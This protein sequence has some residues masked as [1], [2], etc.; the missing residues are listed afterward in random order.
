MSFV[1]A[2]LAIVAV[3]SMWA[4]NTVVVSGRI[5]DTATGLPIEGAAIVLAPGSPD[6]TRQMHFTDSGGNYSFDEVASGKGQVEITAK[7]FLPFQ[8]TNP[9]DVSIEIATDHAE[10]NF[11]LTPTASITGRI[12]DPEADTLRPARASLFR[13]DYTDG[14][15]RFAAVAGSGGSARIESDGS[16]RFTGL[17]PGRYIVCAGAGAGNGMSFAGHRNPDGTFTS[18]RI[19]VYPDIYY[20]GTTVFADAL[21]VTLAAGQDRTAEFKVARGPLFRASGVVDLPGF[22]G[23]AGF[24]DI[25]AIGDGSTQHV[26][27]GSASI[28]PGPFVVEGM[29][30][31]QYVVRSVIVPPSMIQVNVPFT[32][33]DRDIEDLKIVPQQELQMQGS[34]RMANS[35]SPL[36][37]G[38][39]VQFALPSP[40]GQSD[41]IPAADTGEF[42]LNALPG[43]YSVMPVVPVGYAVTE[44]HYGGVNYLNSLIPMKGGSLDSS[45]TIL[46]SE[47]P[48]AVAGTIVDGEQKPVAARI[49][50]AP[51]PLP[52]GFDWRAIRAVSTDKQGAFAFSR[53]APGRYK[54]VALTGDDRKR[55]HDLAILGDKLR[56]ADAFEVVA[57]QSLTIHVQP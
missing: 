39:S 44:L 15:R 51:D 52:L 17:E 22:E 29:P 28:I 18:V 41:S 6:A 56:S 1:H 55:D 48:G 32:I 3:G 13:E 30:A 35:S 54:A 46:L 24:V 53:L 26:F 20:P 40:G 10:H 27:R 34:F 57:G 37:A 25:A 36:P 8:N 14:I 16:F 21:P 45:L 43:D 5:T 23:S 31:G 12:I 38:L 42:W 33:T 47:Q 2:T 11:K 4:Q 7:G 19:E 49:A 50:L 9:D